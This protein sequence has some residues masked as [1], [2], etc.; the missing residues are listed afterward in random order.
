MLLEKLQTGTSV[1][2]RYDIIAKI[3]DGGMGS[4]YSARQSG[5]GR[6]VAIKFLHSSI[7]SD[8]EHKERFKR[9]GKILSILS[10]KNVLH[11]YEF[12]FFKSQ[13]GLDYPFIVME[14][15]DGKTLRELLR[16][17]DKLSSSRTIGIGIQICEGL[18]EVH[19]HSV[20]HRDLKPDN[21]MLLD[22]PVPD[23]VKVVDFGLA[24]GAINAEEANQKITE[25]GVLIG[26]LQYMSPEQCKGGSA[27]N[28]S[29]IYALGCILYECLTGEAAF[30]ADSPILLMKK[31]LTENAPRISSIVDPNSITPG[32]EEVIFKCLAKDPARRYQT[33]D[34]VRADLENVR[35]G[36]V[37]AMEATASNLPD[38]S[39]TEKSASNRHRNLILGGILSIIAVVI[40]SM[41]VGTSS[42]QNTKKVLSNYSNEVLYN[43]ST[44]ARDINES[45]ARIERNPRDI[46]AYLIRAISYCT[47]GE[48]EKALKDFD[49]AIELNPGRGDAYYLRAAAYDMMDKPREALEDCNKSLQLDPANARGYTTRA[50]CLAAL[51]D[52]KSAVA[53]YSR[54]LQI[55]P[56]L[57]SAI[58]ARAE[59]YYNDGQYQKALTD[60]NLAIKQE[61]KSA[62]NYSCR[63]L[64]FGSLGE[65]PKEIDDCD[66]A[67]RLDPKNAQAYRARG[68]GF[69]ELKDYNKAISNYS[70]A[71][72]FDPGNPRSYEGR[73]SAYSKIGHHD[74]AIEDFDKALALKPAPLELGEIYINRAGEFV[75]LGKIE[76]AVADCSKAIEI[77]PDNPSAYISRSAAY[78]A[79][80]RYQE[81]IADCDRAIALKP[82]KILLGLCYANRGNAY[83]DAGKTDLA[84]ADYEKS[85]NL[86]PMNMLL[87][88]NMAETYQN[89]NQGPKAIAILTR[90]LKAKPFDKGLLEQRAE[91]YQRLGHHD[92][93]NLD[94]N[95]LKKLVR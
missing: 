35:D 17:E 2:G 55:N 1:E 19:A 39:P 15:L 95:T 44:N 58:A 8:D 72:H 87:Y 38:P 89:L 18:Q 21:I 84:L 82:N 66:Q 80:G 62:S 53:D 61:P 75:L 16:A 77:F 78:H 26:S 40:V 49:K 74:K 76:E 3:G 65:Y 79:L 93:A 54:A 28:Q 50:A 13:S 85:L 90:G 71:I 94:R 73:G 4:V 63:A 10:H 31:Q 5:L 86:A 42:L 83:R 60:Y 69:L 32:L 46:E 36:K 67:L 64:V 20:V 7:I 57:S 51:G 6:T 45:T 70:K 11:F 22:S 14:F 30:E 47:S 52:Y 41:V 92:L 56:N 23:T 34:A 68:H 91:L 29:D 27:N 43:A 25:T 59:A 9:E 88:S 12:G 33:M 81:C 24:K 37:A 48:P